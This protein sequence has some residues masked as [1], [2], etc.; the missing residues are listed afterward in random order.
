MLFNRRQHS[1]SQM[2]LF[3]IFQ[4]VSKF[5]GHIDLGEISVAISQTPLPP[6]PPH[7]SKQSSQIIFHQTHSIFR[8]HLCPL[9]T[10]LLSLQRRRSFWTQ[11]SSQIGWVP[12]FVYTFA[13]FSL[14]RWLRSGERLSLLTTFAFF[15]LL[16]TSLLQFSMFPSLFLTFRPYHN[17]SGILTGEFF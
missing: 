2:I 12:F 7:P 11:D 15:S 4:Q 1:G 5:C 6:D 8:W 9:N 14:F 3:H 17:Q 10:C 16:P 13:F